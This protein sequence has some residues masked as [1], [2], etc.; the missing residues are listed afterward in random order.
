[1]PM[2]KLVPCQ[3]VNLR[4]MVHIFPFSRP[5]KELG[6]ISHLSDFYVMTYI[7]EQ[8]A[9]LLSHTF[10]LFWGP[11]AWR[12]LF[13]CR[14]FN[15][16][17]EKEI[18]PAATQVENLSPWLVLY[19]AMAL[20]KLQHNPSSEQFFKMKTCKGKRKGHSSTHPERLGSSAQRCFA[21]KAETLE[22]KT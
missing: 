6:Q 22:S 15:L 1:M 20:A 17:A 14:V 11:L 12:S 18:E 10:H 19:T 8:F 2:R 5:S 3:K 21:A 16:H 7:I 13:A 4:T 9:E